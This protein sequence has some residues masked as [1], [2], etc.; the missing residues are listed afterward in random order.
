MDPRFLVFH[1]LGRELLFE[2]IP[3]VAG[4]AAGDRE[5]G[6]VANPSRREVVEKFV[7]SALRRDCEQRQKRRN[8]GFHR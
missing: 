3:F 4:V 5:V 1:R 2:P 7:E 6:I 8:E